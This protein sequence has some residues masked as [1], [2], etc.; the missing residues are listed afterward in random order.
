MGGTGRQFGA[1]VA[2]HAAGVMNSGREPAA[3]HMAGGRER[4]PTPGRATRVCRYAWRSA[5]IALEF[6][7]SE[8]DRMNPTNPT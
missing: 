1:V 2:S 6:T 3:P 8:S 7:Q 4:V 5:L